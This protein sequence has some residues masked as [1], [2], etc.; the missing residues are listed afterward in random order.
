MEFSKDL[1]SAT[2]SCETIAFDRSKVKPKLTL[3]LILLLQIIS[4]STAKMTSIWKYVFKMFI[5]IYDWLCE[6]PLYH[7]QNQ[8]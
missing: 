5:S 8:K 3:G 2:E 6:S 1:L 4:P 7:R